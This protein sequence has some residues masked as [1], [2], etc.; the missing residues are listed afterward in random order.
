MSTTNDDLALKFYT[1]C[2]D[3]ELSEV[4]SILQSE[5]TRETLD[6]NTVSES[7]AIH[8]SPPAFAPP[9]HLFSRAARPRSCIVTL[10][11]PPSLRR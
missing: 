10:P 2:F 9:T 4:K 3:G 11:S 1:A 6:I 7:C 8:T 5:E